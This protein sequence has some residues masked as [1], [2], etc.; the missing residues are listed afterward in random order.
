MNAA[1]S[2]T[3]NEHYLLEI[4][5]FSCSHLGGLR[6]VLNEAIFCPVSP[7]FRFPKVG[8]RDSELNIEGE[9]GNTVQ[10]VA[11]IRLVELW[12]QRSTCSARYRNFHLSEN[13]KMETIERQTAW[14]TTCRRHGLILPYYFV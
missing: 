5:Q 13:G 10:Y 1:S 2:R 7:L 6:A 12:I 3:A 14:F 11:L 4:F 8:N 9:C